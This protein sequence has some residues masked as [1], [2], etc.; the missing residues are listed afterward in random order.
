M[1]DSEGITEEVTT[2]RSE[3]VARIARDVGL[4]KGMFEAA[5]PQ[6]FGW[7]VNNF[8]PEAGLVVQLECLPRGSRGTKSLWGRA[9]TYAEV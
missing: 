3:G 4:E 9:V 5:D 7:Y 6:V 8:G 2:W 1:I